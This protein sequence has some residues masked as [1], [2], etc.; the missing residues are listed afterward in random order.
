MNKVDRLV[1]MH[2]ANIGG[3][4]PLVSPT[5]MQVL[6]FVTLVDATGR[7]HPILMQCCTSFEVSAVARFWSMR[8]TVVC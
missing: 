5:T 6:R 1:Q 8:L 4:T 7:E 2:A 3:R